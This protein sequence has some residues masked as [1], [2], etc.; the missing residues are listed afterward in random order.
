M[1]NNLLKSLIK[2]YGQYSAFTNQ[3][4]LKNRNSSSTTSMAKPYSIAKPLA[5]ERMT[6]PTTTKPR[7]P[8]PVPL[9]K[10]N[11]KL[12]MGNATPNY[13]TQYKNSI[14]PKVNTK[15]SYAAEPMQSRIN[16]QY[17][18]T[19][20]NGSFN[21]NGFEQ[22]M[23]R[24]NTQSNPINNSDMIVQPTPVDEPDMFAQPVFGGTTKRQLGMRKSLKKPI[25][26][27][28]YEYLPQRMYEGTGKPPKM[29]STFRTIKSTNKFS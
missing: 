9:L 21:Q 12:R 20:N 7:P 4:T 25:I 19:R 15:V 2:A 23:Q 16:N 1:T 26:M 17:Y 28:T 5:S 3:D 11:S 29:P 27:K 6:R 13:I 24:A 10:P 18:A 22:F 14:T 8:S